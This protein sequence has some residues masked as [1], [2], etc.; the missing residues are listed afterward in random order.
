MVRSH[1][2]CMTA[3]AGSIWWN[4][5]CAKTA[6]ASSTKA[7]TFRVKSRA[8]ISDAWVWWFS[9]R[10]RH[11]SAGISVDGLWSECRKNELSTI[12]Q[13]LL[14]LWQ[15]CQSK[16]C[17]LNG[18]LQSFIGYIS[19]SY[20]YVWLLMTL[21]LALKVIGIGRSSNNLHA[22]WFWNLVTGDWSIGMIWFVIRWFY[23]IIVLCHDNVIQV[24]CVW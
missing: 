13:P 9:S 5:W 12:I 14:S 11:A 15:C 20:D 24:N 16:F 17:I 10:W 2:F 19:F 7:R 22:S 23:L 1:A 8:A 21:A 3:G 4:V 18:V 6:N